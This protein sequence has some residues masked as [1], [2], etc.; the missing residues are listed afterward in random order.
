MIFFCLP[1][2]DQFYAVLLLEEVSARPVERVNMIQ[3]S[4]SIIT[5]R[6]TIAIVRQAENLA[7]EIKKGFEQRDHRFAKLKN[8]EDRRRRKALKDSVRAIQLASSS[9]RSR[10]VADL[11]HYEP[12]LDPVGEWGAKATADE[13]GRSG[14]S[15]SSISEMLSRMAHQ[16]SETMKSIVSSLREGIPVKK[17]LRI[18][19]D[20]KQSQET[21]D[22]QH[23]RAEQLLSALDLTGSTDILKSEIARVLQESYQLPLPKNPK[24]IPTLQDDVGDAR[25]E[26]DSD[27]GIQSAD[28]LDDD[29]PDDRS[30]H[31]GAQAILNYVSRAPPQQ[32]NSRSRTPSTFRHR[33]V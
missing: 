28:P 30:C 12:P 20:A 21:I 29:D 19:R 17:L 15:S 8:L 14:T 2:R 26:D 1:S 4:H 13:L 9:T 10:F 31:S 33:R 11:E 25:S 23:A 16:E 7:Q 6:G 32:A 18:A 3:N 5:D 22:A 24:P 27:D